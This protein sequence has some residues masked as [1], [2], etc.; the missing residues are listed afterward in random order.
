MRHDFQFRQ[1][2]NALMSYG[3]IY[4]ILISFVLGVIAFPIIAMADNGDTIVHITATGSC[5]H[6]AGCFHLRSDYTI[7]LYEAVVENGYNPCEDCRPPIYDGP[8]PL[9]D[10]MAKSTGGSLSKSGKNISVTKPVTA[11]KKAEV[12]KNTTTSKVVLDVMIGLG[13]LFA[14]NFCV[15]AY[16]SIKETRKKKAEKE[17]FEQEHKKYMKL[18]ANKDPITLVDIPEGVFLKNGLPCTDNQ[19]K[20]VYGDYTVFVASYQPRVMHVRGTCGKGLRA[21]N[22]Y[23]ACKLPHCKKCA[24]GYR[25][26]LPHI[27]WYEDYLNIVEMKKKYNVP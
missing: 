15:E 21:V 23:E 4:A 5:Y 25:L 26:N 6:R 22:Y 20:G 3:V 27:D 14:L 17:F 12:E 10:K 9:H 2:K 24:I 1:L 7:T 16:S 11:T 8:E 18:Y 19:S 13:S